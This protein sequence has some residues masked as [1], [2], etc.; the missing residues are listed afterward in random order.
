MNE[1]DLVEQY[2]AGDVVH[3]TITIMSESGALTDGTVV[4]NVTDPNG[5]AS[6]PAVNRVSLG[7]YETY[8]PVATLGL[9]GYWWV[10]T[11]GAQL[12]KKGSFE[13]N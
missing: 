1:C 10:A 6:T 5:V 4:C 7:V 3:R 12:G 13:V 9:W 8:I 2:T 11:G